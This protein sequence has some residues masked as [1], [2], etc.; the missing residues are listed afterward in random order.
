MKS[1]LANRKVHDIQAVAVFS[2]TVLIVSFLGW[3]GESCPGC[4]PKPNISYHHK[5]A[6]GSTNCPLTVKRNNKGPFL[7]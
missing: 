7:K 2:Y 4:V 5:V 6:L 1:G 3:V